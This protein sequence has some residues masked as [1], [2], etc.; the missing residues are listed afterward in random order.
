MSEYYLKI[1]SGNHL[2]AEIPLEPGNYSLGKGENCDLILTDA[3]LADIDLIIEIAEDGTLQV[4][5]ENQ[6][7]LYLNGAPKEQSLEPAHFD[8]FTSGGIHFAL[9]PV[10]AE[11]PEIQLPSLK[12]PKPQESETATPGDDNDFPDPDA[13]ENDEKETEDINSASTPQDDEDEE[14]F[15]DEDGTLDIDK[16]WL[17]GLPVAFFSLMVVAAVLL[18]SGPEG[19][20]PAKKISPMEQARLIKGQLQL[21]DIKFRQLPD[22]TL[23]LT[24]YVQTRKKKE[25]LLSRLREQRVAFRSQIVV[26]NDMR[27]NAEALLKSRGY[28]N[29]DIELDN[30]PGSLVLTGYVVSS[31][32][33]EKVVNMLKEEIYGLTAIVDQVENQTGRLNALKAM[34]KEKGLASRVHLIERPG[35]VLIQ[36]LLL[37]E[38]QHYKLTE[39]VNQFRQRIG[40]QP[41][42]I[43]ATRYAQETQQI[44][45]QPATADKPPENNNSSALVVA[46]GPK[47]PLQP[48]LTVRGVSMGQIPYV[49]MEDGGKYLIGAKL[50]NGY[51]I[52]DINLDFLLLSNGTQQIKYRLGGKR[53]KATAKQ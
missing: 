28:K 8:V 1:L 33:L 9:G 37:D 52:E 12:K 17:I 2:G 24:G 19:E 25:D 51:I 39:I 3:S 44:L 13:E 23:L 53:G 49:I 48:A 46:N 16:K 41:E 10:D 35:K 38:G 14:E 36:G 7:H 34:I 32:Q 50:D 4:S 26:M 31:D 18:F 6:S 47:A 22:K 29:L 5:T 20:A 21:Q 30:T 11:W 43:I 45:Q 40:K 42:L 15:D 27:A